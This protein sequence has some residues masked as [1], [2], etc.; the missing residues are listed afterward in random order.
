MIGFEKQFLVF[1]LSGRLR[2]VKLYYS[3]EPDLEV[4]KPFYILNLEEIYPAHK[5]ALSRQNL[6]LGFPTKRN[7]R[8]AEHHT[9]TGGIQATL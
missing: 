2:Q 1:F 5:W 6:S 4:T 8:P 3:K 7:S 9:T